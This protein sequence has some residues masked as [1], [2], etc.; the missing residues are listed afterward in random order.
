[1]LDDAFAALDRALDER[2]G[3]LDALLRRANLLRKTQRHRAALD[4]Y[5]AI[6]ARDANH[7]DALNHQGSVL[8]A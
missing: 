6:L 4:D 3:D 1:M 5:A 7:V 2:P 8:L